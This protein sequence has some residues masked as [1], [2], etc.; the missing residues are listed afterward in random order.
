MRRCPIPLF[1]ATTLEL[2][3]MVTDDGAVT[4]AMNRVDLP[5]P[6]ADEVVV[7]IEAAPINPSD[8]GMLFA[9]ADIESIET[10]GNVD[11][12]AR[13]P[14]SQAGSQV[15][16]AGWG[17]RCPWAMKAAAPLSQ[18]VSPPQHER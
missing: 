8:L 7:R 2:R 5:L 17:C 14:Q 9:G 6:E 18:L 4:L 11:L 13:A 10:A 15:S 1:P 12:P 16:A 3:S